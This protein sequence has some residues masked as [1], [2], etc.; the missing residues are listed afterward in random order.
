MRAI[1]HN[2]FHTTLVV[3]SAVTLV[4]QENRAEENLS[5]TQR[6][7]AVVSGRPSVTDPGAI[8]AVGVLVTELAAGHFGI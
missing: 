6:E 3:L 2:R 7:I 8:S 1:F 4:S 5:S